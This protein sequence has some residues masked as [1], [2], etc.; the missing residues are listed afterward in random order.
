MAGSHRRR[1]L[2]RVAF[3]KSGGI[4]GSPASLEREEYLNVC[5][6]HFGVACSLL[7][8]VWIKVFTGGIG[9]D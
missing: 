8:K 7:G 1:D 5:S 3:W 6:K 4:F 9:F 2:A